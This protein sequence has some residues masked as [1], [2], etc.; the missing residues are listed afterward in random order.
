MFLLLQNSFFVFSSQLHLRHMFILTLLLILLFSL[1]MFAY[2]DCDSRVLVLQ[3]KGKI[4][5]FCEFPVASCKYKSTIDKLKCYL[6]TGSFNIDA[7]N[8]NGK[9]SKL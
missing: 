1:L 3:T 4:A 5:K 7:I 6:P 8:T 2:C 9:Y